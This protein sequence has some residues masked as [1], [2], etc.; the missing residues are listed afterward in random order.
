MNRTFKTTAEAATGT[1]LRRLF[2]AEVTRTNR[3]TFSGEAASAHRSWVDYD[4]KAPAS[5]PSARRTGSRLGPEPRSFPAP[6]TRKS[7]QSL[8]V[9]R[10][11]GQQRSADSRE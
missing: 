1:F 5:A 2:G 3:K 10:S 7:R 9:W 8:V 11:R 6:R 4:E